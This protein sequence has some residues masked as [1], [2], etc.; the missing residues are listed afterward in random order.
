MIHF[1]AR[2]EVRNRRGRLSFYHAPAALERGRR[3]GFDARRPLLGALKP[4][5]PRPG[6]GSRFAPGSAGV[7]AAVVLAALLASFAP[8]ALFADATATGGN[9]SFS[10]HLSTGT[11]LGSSDVL[12]LNSTAATTYYLGGALSLRGLNLANTGSAITLSGSPG[13]Y[14]SG[15]TANYYS[16][17]N[18][19]TP[20]GASF[21]TPILTTTIP[22]IN[23]DWSS[24]QVAGTGRSDS[25]SAKYTGYLMPSYT[26]SYVISAYA[27]DGMR[28]TLNGRQIITDWS[29]HGFTYFDSA[30]VSLVA[31]SLYSISVEYYEAGGGAGA[32][33][34]WSNVSETANVKTVVPASAF[35]DMTAVGSLTLGSSGI[36]MSASGGDASVVTDISLAATQSW[37]VGTG[38]TLL[39]SGAVSGSGYGINKLGGGVLTLSGNNTYTGATSVSAGTLQ[40]GAGG[41]SG[42]LSPASA[43]TLAGGTL[44]F[45]RSDSLT[46]GVDFSGTISGS[47]SVLKMG[48]GT[49][50]LLPGNTF[51]GSLMLSSG[52]LNIIGANATTQAGENSSVSIPANA[53]IVSAIYGNSGVS[54]GTI[55]VTS[56]VQSYVNSG[57]SNILASNSI[58]TDP[59]FG[60]A[61]T[62]NVVYIGDTSSP[63]NSSFGTGRLVINGGALDN[64]IGS[65]ATINTNNP[66]SW[67]GDFT[68]VGSSSLN[69][70]T[71]AVALGASP[72]VTVG[73][74]TL[75]VGGAI[76][77]AFG[78]TKAGPGRLHLTG[79]NSYTGGTT[80]SA[81]I[82]SLGG[83]GGTELGTVS[84]AG[85]LTLNGGAVNFGS[86]TAYTLGG[87]A[88]SA[89]LALTN[90]SAASLALTV[91]NG[92]G[93]SSAYSGVLSGGG[94]LTKA[95][96][97]GFT[98]SGASSYTGGTSVE[99]GSLLLSGGSNRLSTSGSITASG[100]VLDLGGFSQSTSGTVTISGGT[101]RNGTLASSL[102]AF[103][104]QSGNVSAVLDGARALNKSGSGTL[105]LSGLNTYGGGT[106]V[107]GGSL[108]LSGGN[109]RLSITGAITAAGGVLDLG[110]FNQS[111][112]GA[113]SLTGG[114]IQNGT[115]T[116]TGSAFDVRSGTVSAV[117]GGTQA[118]VKTT[119]G[120]VALTGDNTYT[121]GTTISA[122][123]LYLGGSSG[124]E[125]GSST[126]AGS[127]TMN[128]GVLNFG[129]YTAYTFSALAGSGSL[130]LGNSSNAPVS[131][132]LGNSAGLS[133]TF[134]GRLLGSGTLNKVGPGTATFDPGVGNIN[135]VGAVYLTG[136]S[137]KVAS[138][139]FH[140]SSDG[141]VLAPGKGLYVNGGL[142]NITGGTTSTSGYLM[143]N[144]GGSVVISGGTL[145]NSFELLNAYATSGTLTV[146]GTGL[147]DLNALRLSQ[148][149]LGTVNLDGGTLQMN[150]ITYQASASALNFNGTTVRAKSSQTGF[151]PANP[152][153]THSI[154]AGGAIFDS[155][156]FD[157]TV[158]ADLV[159]GVSNDGGL[160]KRGGGSLT[161]SGASSFLGG[162]EVSA[163][164]LYLGGTGA[165][166]L[167]LA[168]TSG[169]LS[170][171]GGQVNFGAYT[172]YTIGGLAGSGALSLS[173]NAG[174]ALTLT[175]GNAK[176]YSNTY[177]AV[178]SGAGSLIKAGSGTFT[179]S[180]L[181]T[182]T[183]GTTVNEGSLWLSG[184]NNRLSSTG[185]IAASG[186]VLDLG[187]YLQ[188][189]SGTVTF[190]SG[191]VQ[192]GTLNATGQAF[193]GQA[194][195]VSAVLAGTQALSKSGTG[196]LTLSA[197]NTYS[198]GT[199]VSGGSLLLSGGG[200]RLSLTGAVTAAG[201]V[202]DFGGYSQS[203]SG[204]VTLSGGTLQNG[205]LTSALS[206]F[207]AQS[208]SV[209]AVLAGT[210]ALNKTTAGA[211]TL[212]AANTF[213]GGTT[214]SAGSL[215]LS[216]GSN[217]L[218]IAGAI[219]AAGGVLDLG[220]YT[221]TTGG[222]VTFSGGVVQNGTLTSGGTAFIAQSGSVSAVLAGTQA[223]VKSGTGAL[224]LSGANTYAGGTNVSAG[225]LLLSGGSDR[226]SITGWIAVA[227]GVLDLGGYSQSTGGTVTFSGGTVQNGILTSAG[228]AFV[229]QSGVVSAVLAGTQALSKSGTG[230]LTLSGANTYSGG[231]NVSAGS[232]LL[233]GGSNR[234]SSSGAITAAGG[235]LDLGANLQSTSGTVTF[236]GGTVQNGTLTSAGTA[237]AAQ[238]GSVSAVLD[239]TV[240]LVKTGAGA[241]TL[242]AAN[243]YSG[244]TT[245][246][247]GSLLLTG[248]S[249]RLS[250][251]G[252]I[253]ASGGVLD[254]GG[255]SQ[256]TS[257]TVTFS[258]GTVQNGTLT[259]S[260]SGFDA[261]SGSVGAVL[262]GSVALNKSTSGALTLSGVN[263]Y[264]GGT[265][266]S[267]G[268]LILSGGSNRLSIT[269]A[270]TASGGV[271]DLGGGS[272]NTSGAVT[273]SGG[274]VQNGTL[275]SSAS[276]FDAQSGSVSAVLG[277]SVALNK[278]TSGALTLSGVNTYTGGTTVTAGSLFL[279]GGSNRLSITGAVT[280]AG[281]VLDLGG[282]GQST[283]GT[284]TL[285]G[286][287][288][289]NG[290]L[291][292]SGGAFDAQSGSVSAV[293][294]G[295]SALNKTTG[296]ALTLSA[297]NTYSGG[298]S[299]SAGSLLLTGGSNRLSLS[300]ALTASGGVLDLGGYS[301][302]TSGTVTLSGATVQ[303]GTLTSTGTAFVAQGGSVSAVL[304]GTQAL[305]KTGS[306]TLTLSGANSYSGGTTVNA[307]SLLLS[308]GSNRLSLS[309]AIT[310]SGG[311]LDLGGYSQSTS[312][313]VTLSGAT[314]Q[315]GTLTSTGTAFVAQSGSVSAVL[316]GTQGLNK[317]GNGTVTLSSANTYSGGTNV[318]AG[319][320]LLSGGSN[321]LSNLGAITSA[322]GVLNLGGNGQSTSGVVTFAGGTVQSGTLTALGSAFAAQSGTAD[323][324]LAGTQGLTKTTGGSMWLGL[325]NTYSG[326]TTVSQGT[327]V[328]GLGGT[329]G[330]LNVASSV[331]VGAGASLT[332]NRSNT[333]AQGTD[334]ASLVTGGGNVVQAGSG[335][336]VLSGT[337]TYSGTTALLSGTL[338]INS[339]NAL[340]TS[341]LIIGNNT[342]LDSTSNAAVTLAS[343]TPQSWSGAFTFTGSRDLNLGT[344][345]VTLGADS[346]VTVGAGTLTVGGGIGG[347]FALNKEGNGRLVLGAAST[348][349]GATTVSAGILS[350]QNGASLGASGA[351]TTI[352]SGATLQLQGGILIAGE[353]LSL[354]GNGMAGQIGALVNVNGSNEFTGAITLAA[355]ATVGSESGQ[356]T[357]SGT[358][359]GAGRTLTLSGAGGG[360]A[361]GSIATTTG[362]VTKTGPGTWVLSG[363]NT[364][365]GGTN[366]NAGTLILNS[367][368]ALGTGLFTIG[369]STSLNNLSGSALTLSA[370]NAQVW[371][372]SFTFLGSNDLNLGSGAVALNVDSKVTV[373]GATLTVGGALNG[374]GSL[375]KE[376]SGLLILGGNNTYTGA[377]TVSAGTL[378]VGDGGASG[379]L[380]PLGALTNNATLRFNLSGQLVQG[381]G[382][383]SVIGG[384]G[385]LVKAGSG[386]LVL[387]GANTYT[388]TTL[389]GGGTL[390]IG[391]GGSTG[392]LSPSSAITNN[393]TLAFNRSDLVVEGT[394]FAATI[395]G[396]GGVSKFGVGTLVFG[397]A[398]SYTGATL[399]EAG[400]LQIGNGGT[401]GSLSA[402]SP[403]TNNAI[404]AFN[405]TNTVAEGTDFGS[406]IGGSGSVEQLGSG[407]LVLNSANTYTGGTKLLAGRLHLG[408]AG[409]IGSG[410]LTISG[411]SLDNTSGGVMTLASNNAQNWNGDF[412][413]IGSK[414]LDMGSGGVVLGG[415]RTVS[416]NAGSLRLGGV[417]SG[418][419]SLT[420]T[421]AGTLELGGANLFS[422]RTLVGAGTLLLTNDNALQNSPFD[423]SGAGTLSLGANV[424]APVLGG[425]TGSN[426][427]RMPG[428]VTSLTL[429]P[430]SGVVLSY[431]GVIGGS[432]SLVKS[433]SGGQV[434]FSQNTYNG[435]TTVTGGMLKLSEYGS[436]GSGAGLEVSDGARFVLA[437]NSASPATLTVGSLTLGATSTLGIRWGKTIASATVPTLNGTVRLNMTGAYS[438]LTEYTVLT[439]PGGL[440]T[441]G[442]GLLGVSDYSYTLRKAAGSVK[443]TPTY[444][445]GL[446]T[447]YWVG[448]VVDGERSTWTASSLTSVGTYDVVSGN[449]NWVLNSTGT[450]STTL[451]PG[452]GTDV[453]ITNLASAGSLSAMT[454]GADMS[455][456]GVTVTATT[457]MTLSDN[458]G[459]SLFMAAGGVTVAA[460][461]GT[462]TFNNSITLSA[463]QTWRNDSANPLVMTGA[464]DT[465]GTLLSFAG[466]GDVAIR[467]VVSGGGSITM[468]GSG[469]LLLA[470]LNTYTGSAAIQSGTLRIGDGG[471]GGGIASMSSILNNASMVFNQTDNYNAPMQMVISG[472]GAVTVQTGS[473]TLSGANAYTGG[474]NLNGGVLLLSGGRDRLATT[475]GLNLLGGVLDLGG[476]EQRTSGAILLSG[477][478]VQNGT[479]TSTGGAFD[480][481]TGVVSAALAG[482]VGLQKTTSGIVILN[483]ENTYT[484]GT[485]VSAGTLSLALGDDRLSASGSITVSAGV[486]DLGGNSQSTTGRVSLT[487][488]TIQNGVLA[489][490]G[491][492]FAIQTGWVSASLAGTAAL[493]K[494]SAGILTLSGVSTY[495]GGTNL[496]GGTLALAGGDDR[497]SPFGD[498]S[499]YAGV[500]DLGGG[501]QVTDGT[502]TLA[503]AAVRNGTVASSRFAFVGHSGSVSA[504]LSG[505]VG[506][507]K[508]GTGVLTLSALNAYEGGTTIT[509]GSLVLD[510]GDDRL[511]VGGAISINSGGTLDLG[512]YRQ[513]SGGLVGFLGGV[514]QNGTL[515]AVGFDFD[516]QSGVVGA[517][518]GGGKGL[519]KSGTGTLILSGMNVYTGG[520]TVAAGS[521]LLSGG[522][523]RL[524]VSGDITASG[525]LLDLGGG[526]QTTSGV[527]TFDGGVVRNGTIFSTGSSFVGR[528]GLV[529]SV[530]GGSQALSKGGSGT[531]TLS[532]SNTYSGGTT[533]GEG[534]LLLS[535][536]S[537]R[538][539]ISGSITSN[540]GVLDLGGFLQE[541]SG[542]VTFSGGTIQ[543]G[544]LLATGGAYDGR[545]GV[546]SAVISGTQGLVKTTAGELVLRGRNAYTGGTTVSDGMLILSGTGGS[547]LGPQGTSGVLNISGG[548]LNFGAYAAYTV[549]SLA[550]TG[551]LALTNGGSVAVALSVGNSANL[552]GVFS[553]VLSGGGSL[554]KES[555][556]ALTLSGQN[557]YVGG[558]TVNAGS[559]I[560]SG[561]DNRLSSAGS[562]RVG[563]GV[564]DFGGG[565]QT[566]GG[567][568]TFS[569]GTL[570]HGTLTS[571]LLPFDARSGSVSVQLKGPVA[572]NK[573]GAGVLTLDGA[574]SYTGGTNLVAGTLLLAG[575]G[576]SELGAPG[577]SG[578][579]TLG[580]GV[581]KFG[582]YTSYAFG[583][584]AGGGSLVL[585]ND[586]SAP[587]LVTIGNGSGIS[588][589]YAGV[590]SGAGSLIKAGTGSLVL[591]SPQAYSG[592][593]TISEGSLVLAAGNN[594]LSA[595]GSI[596]AAGGVL[597]LG[598]NVQS[599]SGTLSLSGGV[600]QNGTLI[601]TGTA[602]VGQSGRVT[603]VLSGTQSLVKTSTGELI[604]DGSNA[605]TG[606]T[607][608]SAGTL[609]LAGTGGN[610]LGNAAE[611]RILTLNGGSLNFGNYTGYK[612]GGLAG[613]G[614]LV[615]QSAGDGLFTLTIGS[616][617]NVSSTYAGVMSGAGAVVKAG[618]GAL[619]LSSM[620][621]YSGGTT[622]NGGSLL[623]SGGNNR[624]SA[625]GAIALNSGVLD[626]G[627]Y[628]QMTS[629]AITFGGA[630]VQNGTLLAMGPEFIL[631]SGTLGATLSGAREAVKNT[632]GTV[633][634][635]GA[636]EYLGGTT[637]NEGTLALVGAGGTELGLPATSGALTMN[638]GVLDFGAY[639]SY[640]VGAL[641]GGGGLLLKNGVGLGVALSVG[642]PT[643]LSSTYAGVLSGPG[644]LIK[645]GGGNLTLTEAQSYTGGTVVDE[646]LLL[647]AGGGNRLAS[648]GSITS[649][650]GVL[651]LGGYR[652]ES[653]AL[654]VFAGGTV[655]NGI[656]VATGT[657]FLGRS[658]TV[659][660]VLSGAEG[661]VKQGPGALVLSA[662][663]LYTG[664]TTVEAGSL[665][666]SGGNHRLS[667]TGAITL[668]GGVLD[669]G[670]YSQETSGAVTIAGGTLQNGILTSA[671]G[672]V[673]GRAGDIDAVLSGAFGL[674]K[675]SSGVL[676]LS[677][678][679]AYTGE[680]R[681]N[682]GTLLLS[683]GDNRLSNRSA[684][685]LNGGTLDLGGNS[686]ASNAAI[687]IAGGMLV[688]GTLSSS[689]TAFVAESGS[690]SA[691]LAGSQ[692]LVKSGAGSILL[693]APNVYAGGTT[694]RAGL[695]ELAGGDD[696][697]PTEGSLLITGGSLNLGGN[698]Q[699]TSGVVTFAGGE[700]QNGTL[701][702][703]GTAFVGL[704]GRI[705]AVLS[706]AQGLFKDGTGS[707]VLSA[708]NDYSGGTIVNEGS[709]VLS[710][711]GDRLPVAGAIESKGGVFDL[712]GST[713]NTSGVV[714][715]AGGNVQNGT[716]V[717]TGT[718]FAARSGW[719]SASLDGLQG[720]V[721]RTSG[722]LTLSGANT[723]S[724]GISLF[725]GRLNVNNGGSPTASAL[726]TGS[727]TL[728]GGSLDNTTGASSTIATN[729]LQTWAGDFTFIGSN[730]LNLGSGAV[731][732]V[733]SV[734][735]EVLSGTLS[736][737]GAIQGT[738]FELTKRGSGTLEVLGS[739]TYDGGTTIEAGSLLLAGASDR[740]STVG[741]IT[742][743]GGVLNLGGHSQT[744]SGTVTFSG[745][746]VQNGTLESAVRAFRGESGLVTAEL[747]GAQSLRKI[748]GG[749]LS[750]SGANR[751]AGGVSLEEGLLNLHHGGAGAS[752]A[753]G[754]GRL[755]IFGGS[756]GN[757][758]GSEVVIST[759]NLQSWLGDFTF[760]GPYSL[761]LGNGGVT[762]AGDRTVTVSAG[763]L[764]VGGVIGGGSFGLTKTGAGRL[765]LRAVETY[766]G[767][768][769]VRDGM[770]SLL[771]GDNP[772]AGTGAITSAGGVLD[773]GGFSQATSGLITFSGGTVQNG[774]LIALDR[775]FVGL[776]GTVTAVLGGT[777]GLQKQSDGNL[778]LAGT[779]TFTG[780]V[781]VGGG[782]L[783]L[784][785][786]N[787]LLDSSTVQ[788]SSPGTLEL[789]ADE[790][791]GVFSG[792]GTLALNTFKLTTNMTQD[793][794]FSGAISGSGTVE[795]QGSGTL[796]LNGS[797]PLFSGTFRAASGTVFIG[798]GSPLGDATL[799]LDASANAA[800]LSSGTLGAISGQGTI[801]L[802]GSTLTI[803]GAQ[804]TTF[805]GVISGMGSLYKDGPGSLVLSGTNAFEGG[806]TLLGGALRMGNPSALGI[807]T[808]YLNGG[809]LTGTDSST[810]RYVTNNV[811]AGG[812]ASIGDQL[813][814][815]P[816]RFVSSVTLAGSVSWTVLSD[817]TVE[818]PLTASGTIGF[819]KDGGGSLWFAK[820]TAYAGGTTVRGGSLFV[821]GGV[822]PL[823]TTGAITALGGVLDLG[824]G[825]QSTSGTITFDG[826]RVQHGTLV[827]T[828]FPYVARSGMVLANLQGSQALLKLGSG[829]V[830]LGG[831]NAYTGGTTV[832][833]GSLLL[834]GGDDR[835][836]TSGSITVVAGS[837]DL[838]G[839]KQSTSGLVT[840]AGGAVNN[841]TLVSLWTAFVVES[842]RVSAT[843]AGTQGLVKNGTG[844]LYLDAGY[845]FAGALT[846]N[847]GS[848]EISMAG[849]VGDGVITIATG[850]HLGFQLTAD[851]HI[852]NRVLRPDGSKVPFGTVLN[853]NPAYHVY[854]DGGSTVPFVT[855]TGDGL[856]LDFIE[857][858][859]TTLVSSGGTLKM[860]GT[861]D[862]PVTNSARLSKDVPV[863][864]PKGG[865]VLM[866][867]LISNG[868]DP[869]DRQVPGKLIKIG[870]GDLILSGEN[871]FSLGTEIR[872]GTLEARGGKA[873]GTGP[874][875][876]GRGTAL[877]L[878]SVS[879]GSSFDFALPLDGTGKVMKSGSGVMVLTNST[880][881]YSGGTEIAAGTLE[882]RKSG[883]VGSGG[884]TVG[885][886]ASFK[887]SV[888]ASESLTLSNPL[889]GDGWLV[890]SSPGT[891][892]VTGL[893]ELTLGTRLE[894]GKL[895]VRS[896]NA[897]G[898]A[899]LLNGGTLS[900]TD[901]VAVGI[902]VTM[903]GNVALET[904][905][906][907]TSEFT[908]VLKGV[909]RLAASGGGALKI[910]GGVTVDAGTLEVVGAQ[911][912][913]GG[914]IK[915]GNG[916]LKWSGAGSVQGAA[917][918]N[919]GTM[920]VSGD[921]ILRDITKLGSG[922]LEVLGNSKFVGTT[923]LQSGTIVVDKGS[924]LAE[925]PMLVV[926]GKDSS[927]TVLDVSAAPTG[928]IVGPSSQ[929]TLKGRGTILG[930]V[931]IKSH[932][933][934]EPGN[935]I[936]TLTIRATAFTHSLGDFTIDP[937]AA[938]NA[939]YAY[940]LLSGGS[941]D[942]VRVTSDSA[943]ALGIATIN[944]GY[945]NPKAWGGRRLPDFVPHSFTILTASSGLL[946][947]FDGINQTAVIHGTLGTF[948]DPLVGTGGLDNSVRMTLTRI[949]YEVLGGGGARSRFGEVLDLNLSTVDPALSSFLDLLDGL[950][951]K[952]QVQAVLERVN[953]SAYA[954]GYGLSARR[955]QDVQ[956]TLSDRFASIAARSS[957][958]R[959]GAAPASDEG[960]GGWTAWTNVY[961]SSQARSSDASQTG[962]F[963]S[964]TN[965]SITGV[966]H[967]FGSVTLGVFG[968]AGAASEQLNRL[969]S[970]IT[971][972]SWHMG[973]YSSVPVGERVFL[974]GA[975]IYGESDNV[976]KRSLASLYSGGG[977]TG[978]G[979]MAGE[980]SLFQFGVD[981]QMA[982]SEVNWS[983]VLGAEIS[984][985]LVHSGA[986]REAGA[987]G[988][989]VEVS[990][991]SES[992][993]FSRLGMELAR[994]VNL[995][996]LP[997]RFAG[998]ASWLH[999]FDADPKMFSARMQ[1000]PGASAWRIE[1001]ERSASDALRTGVSIEAA[1002]GRRTTLRI[1003]GEEQ[1004]Q[1005]RGY[1006][1007][1008]GGVTFT[1009][1010]F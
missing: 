174:A 944:G 907:E 562:L 581:L 127:V 874:V 954:E 5:W 203:T 57:T 929:Q 654:V 854:W 707:L 863:L 687:T 582:S 584:L 246:S 175:V 543:N 721:K 651:D 820:Q 166:E 40:I 181:N 87:L 473:L 262:G 282:H 563:G 910:S 906:G 431:S 313:T 159:S 229:A 325:A 115:L 63:G 197:A 998:N 623:L 629:G 652:Q 189:T 419:Y 816:V 370:N 726:G 558:T 978:R 21:G 616:S 264:S 791:I 417:V 327:L 958:D 198:G 283:S 985:G 217:R 19:G 846:I 319:S 883:S 662:V 407:T 601:A 173:N 792:G 456:R 969:E 88:G 904:V 89:S 405:R 668:N 453:F 261:Q 775:D 280:V 369:D 667:L 71:G 561:G 976:F 165:G 23:Y 76:S 424:T 491:S 752:S 972:D 630:V 902:P 829:A 97:G 661:L 753:L 552:S 278:S 940:S 566:T 239:G 1000:V 732:L 579:L 529:L 251:A 435:A 939:E 58:F 723:F 212:S 515:D 604:L 649:N 44:A 839:A 514:L 441:V 463:A 856:I 348:Y 498:L 345:A 575:S 613:S 299:V 644:S 400:V 132:T 310:A 499:L 619:S 991:E 178:L 84:G 858:P 219:T 131:L 1001:S 199:T 599:T 107:S 758:S 338:A 144:N 627:G 553:G 118:L 195:N 857:S 678:A 17:T 641:R 187:G 966:E 862:L 861:G 597:D 706:G 466:S 388:G 332:F 596:F 869:D 789:H 897:L 215:L 476:N 870:S 864:V 418:A 632:P 55:D 281:G 626:L 121:G 534:S 790:T 403:I 925:V 749:T 394:D 725:E 221:Q 837:L 158:A 434:L 928:L 492:A 922:K 665:M 39:V 46:Q 235:V 318:S 469:N 95:G 13:K 79:S 149:V 702:S 578:T 646:G 391:S 946:G 556:G 297:V 399:I 9:L 308:G 583:A 666:L 878:N 924:A 373:A 682:D 353:A 1002:V 689:G 267:A 171:N 24:N 920:E 423:T 704:S 540:G 384:S 877:N 781:F 647:L 347:A 778:L 368:S 536:G 892:S 881:S 356:L 62:L 673:S 73:A 157:V 307:G 913:A 60:S 795:K 639:S 210:V 339:S 664:G 635:S 135:S 242:S 683:G 301:Q 992:T 962:G 207:D 598:G 526:S 505:T 314:V 68:F 346:N 316:A 546:V 822:N 510:G 831:E 130:T 589:S 855:A 133:G 35:V 496:N 478:T 684:I 152:Y 959:A 447:A 64:A 840:I 825:I 16:G 711:G 276:G 506:L 416:V 296:G 393:A 803:S 15:L 245:V 571:T 425:L 569:G 74:G 422:S 99:G 733:S 364:Y 220:G 896:A 769:T 933:V 568:L 699:N 366:L 916:T 433:G 648:T 408:N 730:D 454:L 176:G 465:G 275:T 570:Q 459:S 717:S 785:G 712:G 41:T 525:G 402:S 508:S 93:Y 129:S 824:G 1005:S 728:A 572:L 580:G 745:G 457:P 643:N 237:F 148:A 608:L 323:V 545:G 322:G 701:I 438:S 979:K 747:V 27:D 142:L 160:T 767:G 426:N 367:S 482:S 292:S 805:N 853:L 481:R 903:A 143:V 202:L 872:E 389:V 337:N 918:V 754:T 621:T 812:D 603:A 501:S 26:G 7:A 720:L 779:N 1009:I 162:T 265:T 270:I 908:G 300:G 480:A 150:S 737:G 311:V 272:Q 844:T 352:G 885:A 458:S 888:A 801:L 748:T 768:T 850:A 999:D 588:S 331:S 729:N 836:P 757:A 963:S 78:I 277:G 977:G 414:N 179:L 530:L 298:T 797:S 945:V 334:F 439:A 75:T 905:P 105:T 54:N 385:S 694:V 360:S 110:G 554:L 22:N 489:S 377:T 809:T 380:S 990:A 852:K 91:G 355:D 538:L 395:A 655:Q 404:L 842:G 531:L 320:L 935:S 213:T 167:G 120:F 228:T 192:N 244:G 289:Q 502:V 617:L 595:S 681:V 250:I 736:V 591:T 886:S 942:L 462:V 843:L 233:S 740:L 302:S 164:T 225:S 766:T 111:T 451:I 956:K 191:T 226:L 718:A 177:G 101:V 53:V 406:T 412:T 576:A 259:S 398:N 713:Q 154:L 14:V 670:G 756:L 663:N 542:A 899:L 343:V 610:E 709:L 169:T 693:S 559:L 415:N 67:N 786:G 593:T 669:L 295:S 503:G 982:P 743:A 993:M 255:S 964:S 495:T 248:G 605:Y 771:G 813:L 947:R 81:G 52:Q 636:N 257:G 741:D 807:G 893:N 776:G 631:E 898:K 637:V 981:V 724:G 973:L 688:H 602:F 305:A 205:T 951:T 773:L 145:T 611:A 774:T 921:Q 937:G 304:A 512:G 544:T 109:N 383:A 190:S 358:V 11:L 880:N 833:G 223:L 770:L 136:G 381:V 33:L 206:A 249:N 638:G 500:L 519:V 303:N 532:A 848:L 85:V 938:F 139:S 656:L 92:A 606:G 587:V 826:G 427:V 934:L 521:L 116:A 180:A 208:G 119:A 359:T 372:G 761:D 432:L 317:T 86:Y 695:L 222:N 887:V 429:N 507:V 900:L 460:S 252:A 430:S 871:T 455:V 291:T 77:G 600:V 70:G 50:S 315:N 170:L 555:A 714:T 243:T 188:S 98:L 470:G 471:A 832:N 274:T 80:V 344:G 917:Q 746:T 625:V 362:S 859:D 948:H 988:L 518:L 642:N 882:I 727:L 703:T 679:N 511:P 94:S 735:L 294:G 535:G 680:T 984:Y 522:G 810:A 1006:I 777:Q 838:G 949:P 677:A 234:L 800:F 950:S 467:G 387:D 708:P 697:L 710:G 10:G 363:A 32:K 930:S 738:G 25:V 450:L 287:G 309:G 151:I 443:I 817:L 31:G 411:G 273:F 783:G 698:R 354:S 134:T 428:Q 847:S 137:L 557:T 236:S 819:T 128:G 392:T 230:A 442:Y 113:I 796:T 90:D 640:T 376:G 696:R 18:S 12:S 182:Y 117:L 760:V 254:L 3:R 607:T 860:V 371:G 895:A 657:A 547:E 755:T 146:K 141:G 440:D 396:S 884:I 788:L 386:L 493:N 971:S 513:S 624:L 45:N 306:G 37:N 42:S 49:L 34:F 66:Q 628:T 573:T 333:A 873:L 609:T 43:L 968:A 823:S 436:I 618:T 685:V 620:Q 550:G 341:S 866:S 464:L 759:D 594:T 82:L 293:L 28:V 793:S 420:K 382:F 266:V 722:S 851:R 497:L 834:R 975:A 953:P 446:T 312:G 592:G 891:L 961:G 378:Q 351:G 4:L 335:T 1004:F 61:K 253:T 879:A 186:G 231:T 194:G 342:T 56:I 196:A 486:L 690:V 890:K 475:G 987:G 445:G 952:A 285:S 504:V 780:V 114:V 762:M 692:G 974:N 983:A 804:D 537:N 828:A 211:L 845:T 397:N 539:S 1008:R 390:Q 6:D 686:Q 269:G 622:L 876:I 477:G 365:S 541:T 410:A 986:A 421:G 674:V 821:A 69:L 914:L 564:L 336:L 328:L 200:N 47:G 163:G 30:P 765:V 123:T 835:L 658:G 719:V 147:L 715:F 209:S 705:S 794:V 227:G 634:L 815:A 268:S 901:S 51:S 238:S 138:G 565:S 1003:Y 140:V 980:E 472:S 911:S 112:S 551:R 818:Q 931:A 994:E 125:L 340:G 260:T 153:A 279:S 989:G 585:A 700:V 65:A 83:A 997:L 256:S 676:T 103:D 533:V 330:S 965:G 329:T 524:S 324:V 284:V 560:L 943:G 923:V 590:L 485:T 401:T 875:S 102:S 660:A 995:K 830:T 957:W 889:K 20:Q 577:S 468:A 932:G 806:V 784:A 849:P 671:G 484:G 448:G 764:T 814:N 653:S 104:A 183:G 413:F 612:V 549:G 808:L 444:V 409:A 520:T 672:P 474:T 1010:G 271:L 326:A 487:G 744:T 1:K 38:R 912:G 204:V 247:A 168:S 865:S 927:G 36:D 509:G 290:T 960:G 108:L 615:L 763:T 96:S 955:L 155:N 374:F 321:R 675:S 488:G 941:S 750:L 1007:L 232:L 967:V 799:E 528:S 782:T 263:T 614:G 915:E 126:T 224:T 650:G 811:I 214:V 241:L 868:V 574:N 288:V 739:S 286:G 437:T 201:G 659:S 802:P 184:G 379:S 523:N 716:L 567:M 586:F 483:G 527:V 122:G 936:D 516:G 970:R 742:V 156:G 124:G 751:F 633:R 449:S 375:T 357:L 867:G 919:G 494:T 827:A 218:S 548:T 691:V 106:N 452:L 161:V 2:D 894:E 193:D 29:T 48:S 216:G 996:G 361:T 479:L 240:A 787:A 172:A 517:V 350:I 772:L 8:S 72:T 926:G 258:G 490:R 100:G 734:A 349:S 461:A 59:C 185:A 645:S 841:G 909:G 798:G 731:S